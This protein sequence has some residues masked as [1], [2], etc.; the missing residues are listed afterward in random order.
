MPRYSRSACERR[1]ANGAAAKRLQQLNLSLFET[2]N[3][4]G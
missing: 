4:H 3:H 2:E 1:S